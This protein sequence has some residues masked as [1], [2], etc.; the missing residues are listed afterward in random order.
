LWQKRK[1]HPSY[2]N[3]YQVIVLLLSLNSFISRKKYEI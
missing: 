3:T 2:T 1:G